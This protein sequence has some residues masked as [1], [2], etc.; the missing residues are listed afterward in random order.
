MPELPEVEVVSRG[1][2]DKI[3]GKTI[4]TVD[5][6][7]PKAVGGEENVTGFTKNLTGAKIINI[8]RKGKIL[9]LK[10][11][12]GSTLVIHL[13]L[14]GQLIYIDKNGKG[15]KGGHTQR[16]YDAAPPHK[17]THIDIAF[18]DGSHLYFNDLRRFGWM[19]VLSEDALPIVAPDPTQADFSKEDFISRVLRHPKI[20]I[21]K[22]LMDQK[23]IAGLGN[24]YV[25][26][27]LWRTR[28]NPLTMV[29]KL[30][31]QKIADIADNIKPLLEEA[32]K[33]GGSSANTYVKLDGSKG[34][35]TDH[36][37]VYHREG[38]ECHRKDGGT[39]KRIKIGGRSTF[40]CPVCQV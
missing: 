24:I 27:L 12:T 8:S 29:A 37:D 36:L 34:T 31:K 20:N 14:T 38:E 6:R 2:R 40:F 32:I 7:H 19:K 13:K 5:V 39:I 25:N 4:K 23:V 16:V 18:S 22:A 15:Y 30:S 28:I 11:S 10:L 26:E 21:Y 9:F 1:L 33:Y 35:F 17:H 3:E